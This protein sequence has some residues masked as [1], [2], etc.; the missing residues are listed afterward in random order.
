MQLLKAFAIACTIGAA[1]SA[2]AQSDS[3]WVKRTT[4]LRQTP[5]P[6]SASLGTLAAQS[7][8]TR[9][10]ARQG[11]W[12]QV[13]TPAGKTGWIHMFDASVSTAPSA[14]ATTTAGALRGF[15]NFLSG[16]GP[17]R[18]ISN[19]TA[20]AGIRGLDAEDIA[21]AQPNLAALSKAEGLRQNA[22]QALQ[23]AQDISVER[24]SID[25]LP[26]P[27]SEL[28]STSGGKENAQ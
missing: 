12:I 18:S 14:A 22:E 25:P 13:K 9:M 5:D 20:T 3:L 8:V 11:A 17:T 16:G 28:P 1:S 2:M 24:R 6:A 10:P 7:A 23:F 4:E 26:V 19:S 15:T 21:N 27:P